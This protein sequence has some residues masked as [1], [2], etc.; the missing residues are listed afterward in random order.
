LNDKPYDKVYDE[1]VTSEDYILFATIWLAGDAGWAEEQVT[2][3]M[4]E[5]KSVVEQECEDKFNDYPTEI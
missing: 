4:L 1:L 3:F 5:F 2:E